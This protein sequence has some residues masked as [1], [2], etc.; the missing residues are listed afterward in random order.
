MS[1]DRDQEI[2]DGAIAAFCR[3]KDDELKTDIAVL[4]EAV[5]NLV[6]ETRTNVRYLILTVCVMAAGK[7]IVSVV[8]SHRG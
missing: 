2:K 3:R 1:G 8:L 4:V 6:S 5:Q 7:E